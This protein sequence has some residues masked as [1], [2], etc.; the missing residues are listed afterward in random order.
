MLNDHALGATIRSVIGAAYGDL[1]EPSYRFLERSE[2]R[3]TYAGI[4]AELSRVGFAVI[5]TT[6]PNDD[7]CRYLGFR[8]D[9]CRI[10]RSHDRRSRAWA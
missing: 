5:E 3:A 9:L 2:P 4:I 1:T 6:D 10:V 8:G 7:V